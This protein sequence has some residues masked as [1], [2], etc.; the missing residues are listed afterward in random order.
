MRSSWRRSIPSGCSPGWHLGPYLP[1]LSG[2]DERREMQQLF[3]EDF[4]TDEGWNRYNRHSWLRDKP[5]FSEFFFGELLPEPHSTKQIE[6]ALAWSEDIDAEDLVRSEEATLALDWDVREMVSQVACPVL[7]IH[8]T[9][10]RA[11]PLE[12]GEQLAE[13]TGGR[14]VRLPGSGHLALVRQ[15]VAVNRLI[16]HLVDS[17]APGDPPVDAGAEVQAAAGAGCNGAATGRGKGGH[18][19][20]TGT[21]P[22]GV[23]RARRRP[24]RLRDLQLRRRGPADGRLLPDR[25]DRAQPR[26]E[27]AGAL[28][29]PALPGRHDRPPGQRALRPADRPR[30]LPGPAVRRRHHRRHGPPAASS[31]R[32]WW[33]S[34]SAPGSR[35]LLASRHP[36]RVLGLVAVAPWI[37]DA[38]PPLPYRKEAID[39]FDEE[40]E[41]YEGWFKTNRHYWQTNWGDFAEF[42]F[43]QQLC[44]PH[45]TKQLEDVV[46]FALE[47]T[48][49]VQLAEAETEPS[50]TDVAR[51]RGDA[52][53]HR[54]AGPTHPGH[55]GPLPA[56]GPHGE[57]RPAAASRA[58][59]PRGRGSPADG[60]PPR[61]GQPGDQEVRRP[62]HRRARRDAPPRCR[63]AASAP[64]RCTSPRPSGSGTY[65]ATSRSPTRCARSD[66][67]SRS[68]G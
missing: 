24:D 59:G 36:D 46:G 63:D 34:A 44:E 20:S 13:L 42:F 2:K 23:R 16:R 15:P 65:A 6:D 5:G 19:A 57:R 22:A 37:R 27:G 4:G 49:E 10:D 38:T 54:Q 29:R 52:A 18:H 11:V 62:G 9:D 17:V 7:V 66:P 50:I 12:D 35:F 51:V 56:P 33:P 41:S 40:L 25:R 3:D 32:C 60:S 47:S 53:R 45:S 43:S 28:P 1:G 8:G 58:P 55:P 31:G 61:R 68:S 64:A 21:R 30:G 14:I 26:L 39:R 67:T 48:A